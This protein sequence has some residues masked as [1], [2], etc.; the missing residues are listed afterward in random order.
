MTTV[1]PIVTKESLFFPPFIV[2]A[3]AVHQ[4]GINHLHPVC[5]FTH[6]AGIFPFSAGT[7]HV[8]CDGRV[9]IATDGVGDNRNRHLLQRLREREAH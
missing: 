8:A 1:P 6:L 5:S 9:G 7:E 4:F 2:M 3:T